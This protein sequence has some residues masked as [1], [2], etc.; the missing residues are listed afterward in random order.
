PETVTVTNTV[1]VP[2]V[3]GGGGS[4]SLPQDTTPPVI[5]FVETAEVN[6]FD[7]LITFV[8]SESSLSFVDYGE[9]TNYGKI[10]ANKTFAET[11]AVKLTTL[12]MGTTY[13]YRVKAVDKGGNDAFSENFSFKTPFLAEQVQGLIQLDELGDI[14]SEIENVIETIIPSIVPPFVEEPKVASTTETSAVITWKTNIPSY[15]IVSYMEE[16]NYNPSLPNPYQREVSQTDTKTREH[17]I[18]LTGLMPNT[19]YHFQVKSF[20]IPRAVGRSDDLTFVTKASKITPQISAV[21]KN[22]FTVTWFTDE[23]ASSIVEYT[24]LSTAA[25]Q[26]VTEERQTS[27]HSILVENLTPDTSYRVSAFGYNS[28][29]NLLEAEGSITIHTGRDVIAPTVSALK[30]ESALFP[31]RTDLVQTAISWTTDEPATSIVEFQQGATRTGDTLEQKEEVPGVLNTR[32]S[33]V[34][35]KFRP[36]GIYQVRAVSRDEAGNEGSSPVRMI[37]T[38][39]ETKSIF[40]VVIRNFED[41]FQFVRKLR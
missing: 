8:T 38:P 40:D 4:R 36:G 37:V 32:H 39:R 17:S 11:H 6:A 20:S 19:R 29:G 41:T 21:K 15:S 12:R 14:Q 2:T 3:S 1:T 30:I 18:L 10:A 26:K 9:T 31:G 5:R 35:T 33:I 23:P 24:N 25:I 27:S 28:K 22:S 34:L 16:W 7:A 13:N